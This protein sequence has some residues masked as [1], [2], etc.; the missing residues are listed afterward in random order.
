MKKYAVIDW[1]N[2]DQFEEL[3]DTEEEALSRAEYEWEHL[4]DAE[5]KSREFFAVMHGDIDED[6]CFDINTADIV[7]AFKQ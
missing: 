1:K 6:G 5:K 2:G 3:F 4:T 7:K